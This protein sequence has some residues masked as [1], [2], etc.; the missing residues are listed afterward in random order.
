MYR[1][2]TYIILAVRD[3]RRFRALCR[4]I[5]PSARIYRGRDAARLLYTQF[6][7]GVPPGF[8]Q[9]CTVLIEI[10][11]FRFFFHERPW[12]KAI[13]ETIV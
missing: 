7:Q 10:I 5:K 1:V 4:V 11:V 6:V 9:I 3:F 13:L 12:A 8:I 2:G